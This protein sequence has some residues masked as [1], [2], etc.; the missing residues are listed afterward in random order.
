M[1][2][3]DHIALRVSDIDAN[4]RWYED[5]LGA[6]CIFSTQFY[7][8]M[9]LDNVFL[10]IIDENHYP[11]EH[12]GVLVENYED[13]PEDGERHEHRDGTIGVYKQDLHGNWVEF[14]W[15]SE[16]AKTLME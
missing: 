15:Y 10:A 1:N 4:K 8:R 9:K 14:I 12:I 16:Q 3:I 13:L 11:Y 2:K 7:H 6:E 5:N